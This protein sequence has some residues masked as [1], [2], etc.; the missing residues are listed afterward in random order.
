MFLGVV[1]TSVL[2]LCGPETVVLVRAPAGSDWRS[3]SRLLG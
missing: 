1:L 2:A 3:P